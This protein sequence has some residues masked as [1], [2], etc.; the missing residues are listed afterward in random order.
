MT[1]TQ[2]KCVAETDAAVP[3]TRSDMADPW[4]IAAVQMDCKLG[5]IPFNLRQMTAR[6]REAARHGAR[7]VVFPECI[8]CGYC[9][10]SHEEAFAQSEPIPGPSVEVLRLTCRELEIFA[11]YGLLERDGERLFNALALVG[12]DGLIGSYRKIHLPYLGADRF[13]TP[14]D[15]PFAVQDVNGLRLGMNICYDGSF[16][17]SARI[18]TLL[19]AELI[20]LPTNWPPEASLNPLHVVPTRAFENRV[21]YA[22]VNRVGTERGVRFI[23]MSRIAAPDGR[24]LAASESDHEEILYADV[25]PELAR[26]KRIVHASGKYE[27]DRIADRRPEMYGPLVQTREKA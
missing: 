7:L 22:A 15:R 18:L 12:P 3:R 10:E 27:L 2:A 9:F 20:V 26:R 14:G 24:L 17:E 8:L 11:V 19:G 23:G 6:L 4:R 13:T 1:Y 5:D 21:Y 25:E 16:P